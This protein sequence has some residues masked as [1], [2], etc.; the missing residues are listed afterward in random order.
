MLK[1][2]IAKL[3]LIPALLVLALPLFATSTTSAAT[4]TL[5]LTGT[6]RAAT[7][8]EIAAMGPG[9]SIDADTTMPGRGNVGDLTT[10]GWNINPD[11]DLSEGRH[12][13]AVI[14]W[15]PLTIP[16]CAT[17]ISASINATIQRKTMDNSTAQDSLEW[18]HGLFRGSPSSPEAV[19]IA[20][21]TEGRYRSPTYNGANPEGEDVPSDQAADYTISSDKSSINTNFLTREDFA[22]GVFSF[23]YFDSRSGNPSSSN[24]TGPG[25]VSWFAKLNSAT[26]TYEDAACSSSTPA[27]TPTTGGTANPKAP[28]TGAMA[29]AG[30][31]SIIILAGLVVTANVLSS[32]MN[33]KKKSVR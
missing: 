10:T 28:K 16:A 27:P 31:I 25:N 6:P 8:Q 33:L 5:Q 13:L 14:Q 20:M 4:V 24:P 32:K 1:K 2:Q 12:E 9:G 22:N 29:V 23:F 11:R 17:S 7:A 30:V 19:Y 26:V 21:M 15:Q 18:A 3:K